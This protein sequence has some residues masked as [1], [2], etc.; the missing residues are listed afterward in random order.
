MSQIVFPKAPLIHI[1]RLSDSFISSPFPPFGIF[2]GSS[3]ARG[4]RRLILLFRRSSELYFLFP[5]RIKYIER[6]PSW[7]ALCVSGKSWSI[8]RA[9]IENH[10][11]RSRRRTNKTCLR[12]SFHLIRLFHVREGSSSN[13]VRKRIFEEAK[14][15][16]SVVSVSFHVLVCDT[17]TRNKSGTFINRRWELDGIPKCRLRIHHCLTYLLE[18][19]HSRRARSTLLQSF[20][21]YPSSPASQL[22][23]F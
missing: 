21:P 4:A 2:R 8:M 1:P 22:M 12:H 20:F 18:I 6:E 15:R 5:A 7:L 13:P 16:A 14:L 9:R 23:P 10:C 17:N 3:S 11:P 19:L